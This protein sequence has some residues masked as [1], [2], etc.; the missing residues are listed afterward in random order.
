MF[1]FLCFLTI[2]FIFFI[3]F[4]GY[5][6][7]RTE[8]GK[9]RPKYIFN[10]CGTNIYIFFSLQKFGPSPSPNF[11]YIWIYLRFFVT[12][13]IRYIVLCSTKNCLVH[14]IFV[15]LKEKTTN[16][17]SRKEAIIHNI[18]PFHATY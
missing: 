18:F 3:D 7:A 12:I 10:K 6:I 8:K 9:P 11:K 5:Y 16:L 13:D 4:D 1:I 2:F 14:I 17:T 15:N